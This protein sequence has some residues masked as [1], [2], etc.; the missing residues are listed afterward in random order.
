MD[1]LKQAKIHNLLPTAWRIVAAEMQSE[2]VV[3]GQWEMAM[4]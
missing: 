1:A 3:V 2:D 4:V